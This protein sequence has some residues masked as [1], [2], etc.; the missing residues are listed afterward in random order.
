M[1]TNFITNI[2]PKATPVLNR[3]R[4]VKAS[5]VTHDFQTDSLT[6]AAENKQIE[7]EDYSYTAIVPTTR[8][9]NTCQIMAKTFIVSGTADAVDLAG[10]KE[11]T[12]YRLVKAGQELATDM[13]W[14]ILQNTA[15]AT[16]NATTARTFKGI[17]GWITTNTT[18]KASADIAQVDIDETLSDIWTAGNQGSFMTVCHS[19]NKRKIAGFTTGVTKNIDAEDKRLVYSVDVYEAPIGGLIEVVA[20][21]FVPTSSV[22]ILDPDLWAVA[23]LRPVKTEE[24]A[25]TGDARKHALNVEFTMESR[26]EN[27]NGS[28]TGTS[29]S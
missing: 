3:L 28:L 20:D 27:G 14:G 22:F 4:R 9:T 25:K 12:A 1:L 17:A 6:T 24:L 2:S 8:L 11:E 10:R 13:E 18:A 26:A 15:V 16:G 5:G 29:T 23:Y 21:H 19:W 7:G